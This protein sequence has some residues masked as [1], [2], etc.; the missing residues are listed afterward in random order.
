MPDVGKHV[1]LELEYILLRAF[2]SLHPVALV[3]GC[4]ECL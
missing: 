1:F 3:T 4:V 2:V